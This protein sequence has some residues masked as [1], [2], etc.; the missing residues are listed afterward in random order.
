MVRWSLIKVIAFAGPTPV[1]VLTVHESKYTRTHTE[2][3]IHV[4]D[5]NA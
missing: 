5:S 2:W 3:Y 1:H 4:R